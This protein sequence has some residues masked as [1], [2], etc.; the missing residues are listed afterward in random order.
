LPAENL[1]ARSSRNSH[2]TRWPFVERIESK[3]LDL[4][5]VHE[6]ILPAALRLNKSV[7]LDRVNHFT[8]PRAIVLSS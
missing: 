5:D 3:K 8:V 2:P 1:S 7:S 6:H 4:F